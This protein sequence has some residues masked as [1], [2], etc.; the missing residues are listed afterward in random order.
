MGVRC[1]HWISLHGLALNINTGLNYFKN[2]VPCGITDKGVTSMKQELNSE[3]DED[4][5]TEVLIQKFAEVFK[6]EIYENQEMSNL[7]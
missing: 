3:V 7:S 5:V 6:S 1:S 4:A 2:I